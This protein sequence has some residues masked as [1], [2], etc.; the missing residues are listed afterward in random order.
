M[1]KSEHDEQL[2]GDEPERLSDAEL[3]RRTL[4]LVA[5]AH[6]LSAEL[7]LQ[8]ERLNQ[9]LNQFSAAY[10]DPPLKNPGADHDDAA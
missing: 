3:L 8:T 6:T 4:E 2:V 1:M 7:Y 9:A 10:I 5:R